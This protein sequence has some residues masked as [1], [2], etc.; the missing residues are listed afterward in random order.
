[1]AT[2]SDQF[3][4]GDLDDDVVA[5]A[6]QRFPG[7]PA[8][9]VGAGFALAKGIVAVLER[10]TSVLDERDLTPARWRL[11]MALVV[12]APPEGATIGELAGHLQVREPTVTG[13]VDRLEKEGLVDRRRSETDRR[14]VTVSLTP[15][16]AAVVAEL[17]PRIA[18]RTS[19]FVTA[20]GGPDEVRA[21]AS[22]L[23][24]AADQALEGP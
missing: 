15:A 1:M 4:F 7:L 23:V 19:A 12:Q 24:T 10:M 14:V 5:G 8:A 22:R 13:T 9:E 2:L 20:L 6:A 21:L 18:G 17:L 11:M 16:G 3:P